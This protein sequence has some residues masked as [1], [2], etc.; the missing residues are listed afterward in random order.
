MK[1]TLKKYLGSPYVKLVV[2]ALMLGTLIG[3][4]PIINQG[5][6]E[7]I[8]NKKRMAEQLIQ[9]AHRNSY[10]LG[11]MSGMMATLKHAPI[12]AGSE[13]DIEPIL[14]ERNYEKDLNIQMVVR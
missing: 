4:A 14:S 10:N 3:I 13:V 9:D 2:A 11:F 6:D 8:E 1:K 12:P 5:A 7:R